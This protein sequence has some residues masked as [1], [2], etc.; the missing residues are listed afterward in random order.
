[1]FR[2]LRDLFY[3]NFYREYRD[4]EEF[5]RDILRLI[6]NPKEIQLELNI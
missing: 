2:G 3:E 1:L 6:K 4:R 5:F